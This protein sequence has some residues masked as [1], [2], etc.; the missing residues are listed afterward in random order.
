[1]KLKLSGQSEHGGDDDTDNGHRRLVKFD[2]M[3]FG[4][5]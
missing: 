3:D 4:F 2:E 5:N 1:M